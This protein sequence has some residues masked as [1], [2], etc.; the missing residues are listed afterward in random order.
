[1]EAAPGFLTTFLESIMFFLL[2]FLLYYAI[3]LLTSFRRGMLEQ[4]W[5]FLSEGI[6]IIVGGEIILALSN[7]FPLT[8]YLF[9]VG[10]SVDAVGVLF[11]MMGFRSHYHI[12]RVDD[13]RL[14]SETEK[15]NPPFEEEKASS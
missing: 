2:L 10:L 1:M 15:K 11:A 4:G 14:S 8:G 5:N 6:I 9:P 7:Y 13:K 3:R 12:W